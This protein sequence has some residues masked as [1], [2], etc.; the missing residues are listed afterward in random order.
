MNSLRTCIFVCPTHAQLCLLYLCS[1][2]SLPL[3]L[4]CHTLTH[5]TYTHTHTYRDTVLSLG[6]SKPPAEVFKLFRGRDPSTEALLR[7]AGLTPVTV[8]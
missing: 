6:G 3:L 1:N 8:A 5:L 2:K 7:H 4:C